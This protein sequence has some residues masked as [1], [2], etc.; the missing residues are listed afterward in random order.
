MKKLAITL[1]TFCSPLLVSAH[2]G[3]VIS[4]EV[5]AANEGL[6]FSFLLSVFK[7]P[8]YIALMVGTIA[9]LVFL[10]IFIPK[11]PG[12]RAWFT[13]IEERL[14][15]YG[16]FLPWMARLSIGIA[17]IG[18][19]SAHVLVSPLTP[20]IGSFAL[21]ELILGFFWLAGFLLIPTTLATIILYF[22]ALT[23]ETYILGNLDFLA[24]TC[25]FL[26]LHS[27]RPGI[28]D[29]FGLKALYGFRL[30]RSLAPLIL[31]IGI[32]VG[33][34]YLALHEK[35]L[36]PHLSE[37]VVGQF[38]LTSA[39]NVSPAMWV[40]SAGMIELFVALF[41]LIGLYTRLTSV[42]AFAVLVVTFFFFKEAV[43][44]HVTLF[45]LLSIVFVMGGGEYSLDSFLKR[46]GI[47][48]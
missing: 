15:S 13:Q 19:G 7:N 27:E 28:D 36:N 33:M 6:D 16:D 5:M 10:V 29:I 26:A 48:L 34:A 24:L 4:H 44:S 9:V 17:L 3:Y 31:R 43:Y 46:K 25:A 23:Q 38:N 30:P 20:A 12:V 41:L 37:L 2:V 1:L 32:G 22:T 45:G 35:L 18:A 47:V 11:I 21:F 39:I 14:G 42:I 40:F 8:N